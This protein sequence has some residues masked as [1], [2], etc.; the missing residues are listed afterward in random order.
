MKT[1]RNVSRILLGLVFI[2]SAFVKGVDPLGTAFRLEDYFAAFSLPWVI[3][4]TVP[5][6]I[7][8]C[9][10]E[11]ITGISMLFNLWIRGTAWILLPMMIFFTV[12]TFFDATY[13]LVPDCGCFGDAVKL[14][15]LQ[16]FL[17]NLVLM[18]LTLPVFVNRKKFKGKLLPSG[19]KLVL[20]VF[21]LL[22][23]SMS[24]YSSRHLPLM[25]FLGWKKGEQVNDLNAR[26]VRFYVTYR[27]KKTGEEKE[28]L[29]PDYPWNDST[30]MTDWSFVGQRVEDPNRNK[31]L[32]LRAEDANNNDITSSI[33][34]NP[35]FQFI[36]VAYDLSRANKNAF[37]MILPFYKKAVSQG[38]SFIC[39]TSTTREDINRFRLENGTSFEY[40]TADDVVLKTMIRSNPGLILMNDGKILGKWHFREIPSYETVMK[41]FGDH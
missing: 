36:F 38:Y 1:F 2:F 34:D 33:L 27:N 41:E 13:N 29:A 35:D 5:L 9:T 24:T 23:S 22:F 10:L 28:Y 31:S 8:L 25:D 26:P 17:K 39:L 12:L 19:E 14:T 40:L 32:V 21:F 6:S 4:W 18:A 30:W 37:R 16:T 20:V 11:F 7:L 3:P 15:N